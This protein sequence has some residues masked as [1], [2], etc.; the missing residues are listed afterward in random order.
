MD[1][2]MISASPL[3]SNV[4]LINKTVLIDTGM[5]T[6]TVIRRISE[7]TKIASV[8]R[9]IL[10]HGHF[11]HTGCAAEIKR[12]SGAEVVVCREEASCLTD[13]E[14][15][16]ATVF[17]SAA[18][19]LTPDVLCGDGDRIPAG[20]NR[21]GEEEFLEV[22]HTPGHT[23]G[24][25]CLYFEKEKLLFS[26]DTVFSDGGIGRTDFENSVPEK[27]TSSIEKLLEKNIEKIYPG[28]GPVTLRDAGRSI[29]R[30]HRMSA[31]MNGC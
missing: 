29:E 20:K 23:A 18:P 17:G 11:D 12:L 25:I 22:I 31:L 10:T 26:G 19:D 21:D 16:A 30:S 8:E 9:I 15:S 27:M 1:I 4:Y 2:E 5:T 6:D 28:H 13:D 3:D 14:I 7:K 24:C